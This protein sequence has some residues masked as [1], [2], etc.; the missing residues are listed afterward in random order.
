MKLS[1]FISFFLYLSWLHCQIDT[2]HSVKKATIFSAILPGSGQ[3]YNSTALPKGKRTAYWKVP[4]IYAGLGGTGYM[5]LKH[6]TEQKQLKT[7]YKAR[8]KGEEPS[9]YKEYDME[10]LETL[11]N[12]HLNQRD[13]FILGFGFVYLM[14]VVDAAVEAHFV[15]FDISE[16]LT[17]KVS[18]SIE[19]AYYPGI[20]ISLN[21]VK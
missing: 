10:G 16:D 18:P 20:S 17:L 1:L 9:A 15:R 11:Y 2:T 21:F 7:E 5:L 19:Q 8:L 12:F 14:Q 4:L 3:V 6:N 13:L